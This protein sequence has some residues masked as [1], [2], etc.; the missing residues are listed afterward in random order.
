MALAVGAGYVL[1]RRRKMRLA[2]GLGAA[3]VT[4]G[5]GGLTRKMLQRGT[6]AL[7]G[8]D[9]MLG[10]LAPELGDVTE[11]V[12]GELVDVGKAAALAA[13]R[14]QLD[15]VSDRLH[16]HADSLRT[17][18]GNRD[19]EADEDQEEPEDR[20]GRAERPRTRTRARARDTGEPE[21]VA[22]AD[23]A[24]DF[25]DAEEPDDP[26]Q[27]PSRPGRRAASA[28]GRTTRTR[29]SAGGSPVRRTGR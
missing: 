20:D 23:E 4:G 5:F 8:A 16:D 15:R 18:R 10:K 21:D 3:A 7:A 26:E 28:G 6:G 12:R 1:G 11:M 24:E 19:D 25:D 13:V 17:G 27:A 9:G 14:G 29:A 2:M 22:E